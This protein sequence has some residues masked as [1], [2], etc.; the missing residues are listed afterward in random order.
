MG[1]AHENALVNQQKKKTFCFNGQ[2]MSSILMLNQLQLIGLKVAQ[3]QIYLLSHCNFNFVFEY[4]FG[5]SMSS[6]P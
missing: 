6:A 3:P 5:E 1:I 2:L 4:R